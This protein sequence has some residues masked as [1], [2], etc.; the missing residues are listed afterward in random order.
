MVCMRWGEGPVVLKEEG[1]KEGRK[2]EGQGRARGK[3]GGRGVGFP[4]KGVQNLLNLYRS[5]LV[6]YTRDGSVT[7]CLGWILAGWS[8]LS[9]RGRG[10]GVCVTCEGCVRVCEGCVRVCEGCVRSM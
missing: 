5:S 10:G 4:P 6:E 9:F 7:P 1:G 2:E 3:M 8:H